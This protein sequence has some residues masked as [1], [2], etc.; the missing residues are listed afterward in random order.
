MWPCF[1][2]MWSVSQKCEQVSW[3][4]GLFIFG[5][6]HFKET[7]SHFWETGSPLKIP[8]TYLSYAYHKLQNNHNIRSPGYRV[9]FSGN[10]APFL[11]IRSHFRE[12]RSLLTFHTFLGDW[13]WPF[14]WISGHFQIKIPHSAD[15]VSLSKCPR[16]KVSGH[17]LIFKI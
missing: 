11:E 5:G 16:V 15:M 3:K 4:K 7:M 12:T 13:W 6:S 2:K 14:S 10:R 1:L 9:S 8:N 17:F